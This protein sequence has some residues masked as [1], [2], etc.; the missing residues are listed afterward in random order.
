MHLDVLTLIVT[1]SFVALISAVVLTGAW[2]NM[3]RAPAL[4][5]WSA[6]MYLYGAGVG[7]I[8]FGVASRW[9]AAIVEGTFLAAASVGLV[10][11]G[12]RAF[13]SRSTHTVPLVAALFTWSSAISLLVSAGHLEVSVAANLGFALLFLLA[14]EY[15]LWR[16]R[17]EDLTAR[18]ALMA[19]IALHGLVLVAGLYDAFRPEA[20]LTDGPQLNS[21]FGLIHFEGLIF[22]IGAP[23]LMITLCRERLTLN[24]AHASLVDPLTG[25]AN[26]RALFA[27]AERLLARCR[28]SAGAFS[29]IEFDLDDF[30]AINDTHGHAVGDAVLRAFVAA[31]RGVLRP[32]DFFGRHGGEEFAVVLPGATAAAAYLIAERARHAFAEAAHG[33]GGSEIRATVSAGV[34]EMK[35][36]DN[37][38][39]ILDAA[40][41]ALYLAKSRG[42]NRVEGAERLSPSGDS[43]IV[44]VA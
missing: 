18:W 14:I 19:L 31:T 33:I 21:L 26:R 37:F 44:R 35:A 5:W 10:W 40:D 13:H 8:A 6:S 16:G 3:A 25:I 42:R 4:K 43:V 28:A 27:R 7:C 1:G 9:P 39:D 36:G 2:L 24:Y 38:A 34:A 20:P 23:V 32:N 17:S 29:V 12:A 11:A 41:R 22:A 15:E 30:K